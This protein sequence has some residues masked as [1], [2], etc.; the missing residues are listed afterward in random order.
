MHQEVGL[1]ELRH[2]LFAKLRDCDSRRNK[3]QQHEGDDRFRASDQ[4]RQDR[5]VKAFEHR[6][7]R[8][9]AMLTVGGSRQQDQR[10]SRSDRQRDNQR[11]QN[12]EDVRRGQRSEERTGEPLQKE[13]WHERQADDQRRIDDGT[14][15]FERRIQDDSERRLRV[16]G[17][18][19]QPQP[20]QDIFDVN[21]RVIDDLAQSD[22]QSGEHHRVDG[23][24]PVVQ[25]QHRRHERQGD[26][27][28]ADHGSSP[29]EQKQSQHHDHQHAA[30]D[31]RVRQ[32]LECSFDKRRRSEDLCIDINV[33]QTGCQLLHR[34][35]NTVRDVERVGPWLLLDD[36]QNAG[37]VVDDRVTNRRRRSDLHLS[38]V[39]QQQR[40]SVAVRD[41]RVHQ[42]FGILHRRRVPN[43][44]SLIR[45]VDEA[46]GNRLD[47][48]PDSQHHRVQRDAV[49]PQP[50]GI[51]EHLK[52]LVVV[53]PDGHVGDSRNRHQP[54]P[55]RPLRKNSQLHLRQLFRR[56]TNLH[57]SAE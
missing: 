7:Q 12:R 50:I 32:V 34:F 46:D 49:R 41:D 54:R 37:H 1:F 38:H 20:S 5:R 43:R 42:V 55:D 15:H 9:I 11:G 21:D 22:D 52:L 4:R 14:S 27:Q 24:T 56:Q 26:C 36:Q 17:F 16:A 8:R 23:A 13:H 39:A 2:Q 35:L 28:R 45:S 6:R 57:G 3:H 18:M 19:I 25:H 44:Q 51:D 47:R 10:Q 30:D 40:C 33:R 48:I 29:V 53:A 31:Q